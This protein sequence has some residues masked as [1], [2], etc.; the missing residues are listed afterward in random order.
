MKRA[1]L[2]RAVETTVNSGQS[3]WKEVARKAA[4]EQDAKKLLSIIARIVVL[5]LLRRN[6]TALEDQ[7]VGGLRC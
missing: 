4:N 2:V 5:I 3:D 6:L 1:A 7:Q